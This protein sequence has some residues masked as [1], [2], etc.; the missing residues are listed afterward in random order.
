MAAVTVVRFH[1]I[2][3]G[4]ELS[5]SVKLDQAPNVL[6]FWGPNV[7]NLLCIFKEL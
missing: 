7:H 2:A 4:C 3:V 5:L 1:G 6:D